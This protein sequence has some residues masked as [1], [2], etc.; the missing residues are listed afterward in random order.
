MAAIKTADTLMISESLAENPRLMYARWSTAVLQWATDHSING[1][2]LQHQLL[3]DEE[4][5]IQFPPI[6]DVPQPRLPVFP[7]RVAG[8]ASTATISNWKYD[9]DIANS[10]EALTKLFRSA[11]LLSLGTSIEREFA[12]P[13]RGHI[14]H[15]I[16]QIMDF[17][18]KAYGTVTEADIELLKD[19]LVL[20]ESKSWRENV[21]NF[22]SIFTLLSPAGHF[23]TDS[24]K[25]SILDKAIAKTKYAPILEKYKNQTPL[26]AERTFDAQCS[27]IELRESNLS[28]S[29]AGY[30]G[31]SEANDTALKAEIA[32]LTATVAALSSKQIT[33][34]AL[35]QPAQGRGGR[36]GGRYQGRGAG[37]GRQQPALYCFEHGYKGHSGTTCRNMASD[38]SYTRAMK[39]AYAPCTIDG[40]TGHA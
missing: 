28:A 35:N 4:W 10:A 33:T 3:S 34:A 32:A 8:N 9:T 1:F 20:D 37:R 31:K 14:D 17:I 25:R 21:G 16:H 6:D 22:K 18:K 19:K 27:Y 7:P 13:F 36:S 12:D 26:L 24:D 23:T 38:P 39:D 15:T 29:E 30:A 5:A 40:F 11:I 2:K